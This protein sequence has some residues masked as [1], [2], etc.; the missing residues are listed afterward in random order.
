M[1]WENGKRKNPR[2]IFS[3][4]ADALQFCRDEEARRAA[5][6]QITANADGVT[7]AAWLELEEKLIKAGAGS[8]KDVGERVLKETL[9]ITKYATATVCLSNYLSKHLGPSVYADDSRNRCNSFVKW[10]GAERPIKEATHELMGAYFAEHTGA[11][12]RRTVSAWFGWAVDEGYLPSN[13]CARKRQ[14]R[15]TKKKKPPEAVILSPAEASTLLRAAVNAKD[16]TSLSYIAI[17]LFAGLRPMEFRKKYKNKAAI[18]LDWHNVTPDGI[19]IYPGLAKTV[20]RVVPI[21]SPLPL[22]I[23][24]IRKKK[25]AL[26]GP[27]V[28]TGKRGGGWR[29]HWEAFLANHWKHAW[30]ADQMRHSFGSYRMA[31]VKNAGQVAMEMGN[32]PAVVLAHYWNWK[33]LAT[34]ATAF[35]SLTPKLVMKPGTAQTQG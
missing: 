22:W 11:T 35:W 7:V 25:G 32:S 3:N 27:V 30:H 33:T 21:I 12:L 1:S 10:F 28:A 29:K 6:G 13:P 4:Y 16:W 15:G 5:H 9:A 14:R 34:D 2:R 26:S 24:L 8:L 23:D 19:E 20:A 17:S 31:V 18:H